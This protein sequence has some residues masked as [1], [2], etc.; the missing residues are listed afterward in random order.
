[1]SVTNWQ[2]LNWLPTT[3]MSMDFD[4]LSGAWHVPDDNFTSE[5]FERVWDVAQSAIVYFG[6]KLPSLSLPMS[7]A[8]PDV[9]PLTYVYDGEMEYVFN[10]VNSYLTGND[11][12]T[13]LW[14]DLT[15]TVP[16]ELQPSEIKSLK[17]MSQYFQDK[18]ESFWNGGI[19]QGFFDVLNWHQTE[20]EQRQALSL[21]TLR[22]SLSFHPEDT[23]FLEK[24]YQKVG[25]W[26]NVL[27]K[28]SKRLDWVE[29]RITD[30]TRELSAQQNTTILR[31]SQEKNMGP[32]W[33][34]LTHKV[35]FELHPAEIKELLG[36]TKDLLYLSENEKFWDSGV[37]KDVFDLLKKHQGECSIR[38]KVLFNALESLKFAYPEDT[39]FVEVL[40][41]R[42]LEWS[43]QLEGNSKDLDRIGQR[44]VGTEDMI[45]QS[46][47]R[48]KMEVPAFKRE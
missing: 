2:S 45:K 11:Q 15:Q 43:L 10:K 40:N 34:Q 30:L 37:I 6:S 7:A 26:S 39:S 41:K 17:W 12:L 13:Q 42:A 9:E 20:N 32:F 38:Q 23:T 36:L 22:V 47:S 27:E 4:I 1:M 48:V 46:A 5:L 14:N 21:E 44:M 16:L 25:Q 35:P 3:N 19:I 24:T 28:N 8:Q 31:F 33:E 18:T 29:T